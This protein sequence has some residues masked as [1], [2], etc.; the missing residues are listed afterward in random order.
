MLIKN[1][2]STATLIILISCN[3]SKT[4]EKETYQWPEGAAAPVADKK[5]KELT[6]HGDTRIDE[7]YWMNDFF[8]KGPDSTKVVDYLKAENAYMDTMMSGTKK[9]QEELFAEMKERIKEKDESVPVFKNGYYYYSRTEDGKQYYKYCR[10]KGSLDAAEEIL[11]D[12]DK[13]AEGLSFFSAGGF[14]VSPDNKLLAYG[15][16]K[17]SR[18]QYTIYVKNLETGEMLS[19]AIGNTQADIVWASDNKTIFYTSKNPVTL[20]SEKIMK[21]KLGTAASADQVVYQEKDNSNYIGVGKT[22]SDKYIYIY[23]S[24]TLSSEFRLI[25]ADAPDAPVKVFQ[26]RIKDVLYSIDH[27]GD[28]FLIV[29]NKD[30]KNFKLV[31]TPVDKTGVENWV[32]V[33]PQ[34]GDVLVEGADGFEGPWVIA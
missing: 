6:A 12:V 2:L 1:I 17:L 9:F 7:Y 15:V 10:K 13:M 25:D 31:E 18:Q 33:I 27:W 5:N 30:A 22:K 19:D 34:R 3:N 29:T 8:K 20:L 32:E 21:H 23:S 4:V 11:L 14:A 28:K 16:D 24:S 26:P